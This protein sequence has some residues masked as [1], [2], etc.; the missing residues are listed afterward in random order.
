VA[1]ARTLTA[2]ELP[3]LGSNANINAVV[4]ALRDAL[5]Q[6]D[7]GTEVSPIMPDIVGE[8]AIITWLGDAGVLRLRGAEV[9][10]S[11]RRLVKAHP[12]ISAALVRTAQDFAVAG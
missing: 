12:R 10:P 7:G 11:I 8:A 3:A 5:P 2:E 6:L 4:V 1:D 9:L